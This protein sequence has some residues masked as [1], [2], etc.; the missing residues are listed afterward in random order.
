M[1]DKTLRDKTDTKLLGRKEAI[2]RLTIAAVHKVRPN[3]HFLREAEDP[4]TTALQM[5]VEDV[6]WVSHHCLA[7]E[8]AEAD[9]TDLGAVEQQPAVGGLLLPAD[10][11][12]VLPQ[13]LNLW[14]EAWREILKL[15]TG[16]SCTSTSSFSSIPQAHYP[17]HVL[18]YL[19][20]TRLKYK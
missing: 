9:E 19:P 15:V 2:G 6:A 5:I 11:A 20:C 10:V 12:G 13:Q 16:V 8:D 7:L 3:D 17:Q 1:K 18:P 14:E 4:E